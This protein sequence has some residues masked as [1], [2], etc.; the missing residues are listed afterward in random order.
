MERIEFREYVQAIIAA[1][2]LAVFLIT[3]V[4]QS[5][6]V[7]G[8]SM[9]PSLIS[10]ERLLVDKLTYRFSPPRLGDIVVFR[11]PTDPRRKFI[12]RVIGLPGDEIS[13]RQG[14]VYRNGVLLQEDYIIGPTLGAYSAPTFGPVKVPDGH[15]FV[16]GDNRRNSDDSRYPDVGFVNQELILGR[17]ILTYWP[18]GSVTTHSI[19]PILR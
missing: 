19:P 8:R 13:I 16:L 3:F 4:A 11:Y 2:L 14:T 7:Q 10:G 18:V 12:K 1:V 6:H 17:A 9:E 5:F 15:F